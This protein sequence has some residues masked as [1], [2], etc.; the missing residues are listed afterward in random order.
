MILYAFCY[1][2]SKFHRNSISDVFRDIMRTPFLVFFGKFVIHREGLYE[3]CFSNWDSPILLRMSVTPIPY[4]KTECRKGWWWFIPSHP[5]I[6]AMTIRFP[7]TLFMA[8]WDE[9]FRCF[10][11]ISSIFR[12]PFDTFFIQ[13]A[14]LLGT[15]IPIGRMGFSNSHSW[16]SSYCLTNGDWLLMCW[17]NELYL[18]ESGS[19]K[20]QSF[21]FLRYSIG[22]CI[23]DFVIYCVSV[24]SKSFKKVW[25]CWV[26]R[27]IHKVSNIFHG[28]YVWFNTFHQFCEFIK[29]TS[30]IRFIRIIKIITLIIV[31]SRK[32]LARSTTN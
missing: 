31:H 15:M 14:H 25:K 8:F 19:K 9:V 23:H 10:C 17:R 1:C 5:C 18:S 20:Y 7:C 27:F 26:F 3:C 6:Y 29:R 4:T 16:E 11:E 12:N 21:A 28:N 2:L 13:I 22:T 30:W 24:F 32:W